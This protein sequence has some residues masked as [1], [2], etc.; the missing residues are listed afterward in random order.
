M[1]KHGF[2]SERPLKLPEISGTTA[3]DEEE[4]DEEEEEEQPVSLLQEST[5][6]INKSVWNQYGPPQTPRQLPPLHR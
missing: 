5:K 6:F 4:Y 3:A 2:N 1:H